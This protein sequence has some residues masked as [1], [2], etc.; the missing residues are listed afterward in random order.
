MR[1][2]VDSYAEI[3]LTRGGTWEGGFSIAGESG[4][5]IDST[6]TGRLEI[7]TK[8]GG[9]LILAFTASGT[10]GGVL[11]I[12]N[13]GQVLLE[14]PS[15]LTET[16]PPTADSLGLNVTRYV[17]DLEVWRKAVPSRRYKPQIAF[18]VFVR[19]EVTIA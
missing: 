1:R 3:D 16:I 8:H 17:G 10:E 4:Y 18:N 5:W 15:S 6:W 14:V 7:R 13:Y 19:P 2:D 12:T 9:D 11:E